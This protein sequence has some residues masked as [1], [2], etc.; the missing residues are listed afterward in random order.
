MGKPTPSPPT[1]APTP[2]P[3]FKHDVI[4]SAPNI[5]IVKST[6]E[7]DCQHQCQQHPSCNYWSCNFQ[8]DQ[9]T[10]CLRKETTGN[11]Q[12][13]NGWIAGPRNC[14]NQSAYSHWHSLAL[15]K[16]VIV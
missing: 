7:V 10:W 4:Y 2:A 9:C 5:D 8:S 13:A 12:P 14:N 16:A 11:V 6:S 1:P 3:C 15:E